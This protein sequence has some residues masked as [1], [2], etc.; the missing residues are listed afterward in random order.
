MIVRNEGLILIKKYLRD[1]N[2]IRISL[3]VECILKEL[4]RRLHKDEELWSLTG[5][6]HNLDYEYTVNDLEKR[7][8]IASQLLD[9]LLPKNSVN[10]IMAN[11]YKHTGYTP[12]TSLDKAMIA[13]NAVANFILS[14]VN[15]T[16][17]RKLLEVDLNMLKSKFNDTSFTNKNLRNRINLCVDFGLDLNLFLLISLN[18]LKQIADNLKL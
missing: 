7:G 15:I 16:P 6:L 10:A 4:A 18:S 9:G 17:S 11:N 14:V 12:T 2:S 13:S 8:S 1:R 3:A 5:L